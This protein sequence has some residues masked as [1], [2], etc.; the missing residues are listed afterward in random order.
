MWD[1]VGLATTPPASSTCRD[2]RPMRLGC[3]RNASIKCAPCPPMEI[4]RARGCAPAPTPELGRTILDDLRHRA[5]GDAGGKP[6][7]QLA[8]ARA[9]IQF[10]DAAH[11]LALLDPS[12]AAEDPAPKLT[13][14][15]AA[16]GGAALK[17]SLAMRSARRTT[18][19]AQNSSSVP[20]EEGRP[21]HP[22]PPGAR[23]G[24]H[25]RG[26]QRAERLPWRAHAGPA[27]PEYVAFAA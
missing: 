7:L 18:K 22:L 10:S 25:R 21:A 9:E 3:A 1:S 23:S 19:R 12:G 11:Q 26:Q 24:A 8:L 5:K 4:R 6:A 27:V 15:W 14:C 2:M 17:R 16:A 20:A 13:T